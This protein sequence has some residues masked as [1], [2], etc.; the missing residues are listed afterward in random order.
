MNKIKGIEKIEGMKKDLPKGKIKEKPTIKQKTEGDLF[1]DLMKAFFDLFMV[2]QDLAPVLPKAL[3]KPMNKVGKII[4]EYDK[5]TN[6]E[7]TFK[8]ASSG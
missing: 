4:N 2:C 6:N 7:K 3:E 8:K 5:V 1:D